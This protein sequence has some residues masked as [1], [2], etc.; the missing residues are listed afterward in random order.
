MIR[1]EFFFCIILPFSVWILSFW[2]FVSGRMALTLDAIS[3]YEHILF[4]MD[5]IQAKKRF[6]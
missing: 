3:Y 5:F 4:F 2:D 1:K 6:H